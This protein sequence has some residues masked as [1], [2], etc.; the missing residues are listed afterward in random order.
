MDQ[1]PTKTK[2]HM[3]LFRFGDLLL[4]SKAGGTLPPGQRAISSFPRYGGHFAR[5]DP[6]VPDRPT[7]EVTGDG[8]ERIELDASALQNL[9]RVELTADFHCVAGWTTR[10][11]QWGGVRFRD[12]Y[13]T[14]VPRDL[15]ATFSHIR[16]VGRDGWRAVLMLEDAL[17][18]DVLL[19]DRLDGAPLPVEH[20]GPIRL[21]SAS[22]YGYKSVKHLYRIEFHAGEPSDAPERLI[23]RLGLKA[24]GL[25]HPR[26]R[27]LHEERTRAQ[28]SWWVRSIAR[29]VH[30]PGYILGYLG[31]LRARRKPN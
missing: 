8:F 14:L 2:R 28:P 17:A 29:V 25:M 10:A 20:G 31:A 11:L 3:R 6:P 12:I 13:E 16:A 19:A 24:I 15:A 18:D 21:L 26:A 1:Q 4:R 5:P 27:V 22:Q 9:P 23:N 7:I 30:P